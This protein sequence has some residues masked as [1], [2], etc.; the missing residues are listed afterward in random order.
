MRHT[1]RQLVRACRTQREVRKTD[2]VCEGL[3]ERR[4]LSGTWSKVSTPLPTAGAQ[5]MLLLTDGSIMVHGGAHGVSPIWEKLTPVNG[6]YI[7][8]TW[9]SL[10]SMN[11]GRLYFASNVLTSGNVFLVGGEYATDASFS[12]SGEVYDPVADSWTM[13]PNFPDSRFGDDPSELLPDGTVLTGDLGNS[14]TYI[15]NP[16]TNTWTRTGSKLRGDR[17]DEETWVTLPDHSILSYDVFAS[18]SSGSGSAQR[19]IPSTGQWVD[20]GTLPFLL[21]ESD[22]GDELGPGLVLPDGR[23]WMTGAN[24]S[25]AFY[26]PST[27][28]WS[29]GPSIPGG[30][31]ASDD[32]AAMMPNGHVL[33]A[34]SPEE[35][36][37]DFLGPTTVYEFD[38]VAGTYTNVTPS[39]SGFSTGGNAFIA[40]M[41]VLP[42]GQIAFSNE[43]TTI[44]I[45]T[46]FGSPAASQKPTITSIA[47]IS[48]NTFLLGGL[49][50]NGTSEGANYG[51]D[52]GMAENYPIIKLVDT[53]N[54]T[55]FARSTNWSLTGVPIATPE[56]VQFTLPT[57]S[58][59]SV[60]LVTSIANG[61]PSPTVLDVMMGAITT[62]NVTIQMSGSSVQVLAD[63]TSIGTFSTSTFSAVMVSGDSLADTIT[64]N[65]TLGSSIPMYVDG[66]GGDDLIRI[67]GDTSPTTVNGGDGDDEIDFSPVNHNLANIT[68]VV[69]VQGG[70][71][72]DIVMPFD[73]SF[74]TTTA[75]TATSTTL[76]RPGF[77]GLMYASDLESVAIL[78]GSTLDTLSI[79]DSAD[80]TAHSATIA[81]AGGVASVAGLVRGTITWNP[82][83]LGAVSIKS[84]TAADTLAITG[85]GSPTTIDSA[86]G[87]DIIKV[88]STTA[89][90]LQNILNTLTITNTPAL[91]TVTVDDSGDATAQTANVDVAGT[92]ELISTV[93]PSLIRLTSAR[94]SSATLRTG[95]GDDVVNVLRNNISLSVTNN[96]GTDT[97]N[98]GAVAASGLQGITTKVTITDPPSFTNVNFND[99]GDTT[100][101][102]IAITSSGGVTSIA[103]LAPVTLSFN[104][105]DTN[106]TS[107]TTG[108]ASD[109]VNV[110]QSQNVLTFNSAGGA[111]FINVGTATAGVQGIIAPLTITDTAGLSQLTIDDTGDSTAQT[112]TLDA[113]SVTGLAPAAISWTAGQVNFITFVGGAGNDTINVAGTGP[114]AT[115]QVN[116]GK[117]TDTINVNE[118]DPND[119]VIIVPSAG[120]DVINVNADGVGAAG[121]L[122]SNTQQIGALTVGDNGTAALS[123][124]GNVVLTTPSLSLSA[125]S[126]LDV[127]N[128]TLI[129]DYTGVS[130]MDNIRTEIG[131]GFNGGAWTGPQITSS[132]ARGDATSRHALGYAEASSLGV[133]QFKGQ[134]VDATSVIIQYTRYGDNNLDGTID[135]GND[136][137]LLVD[138]LASPGAS[139]WIQGDYTYDGKVDLGNDFNLF[140]V[141]YLNAMTPAAAPAQEG[142]PAAARV[143][144]GGTVAAT[145]YQS[146]MRPNAGP[147]VNDD[148]GAGLFGDSDN[149][150][151]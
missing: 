26:T 120:N 8:G 144:P 42:T 69:S 94:I 19:Y 76:T 4:L 39:V 29:A 48:G 43:S 133:S 57:G 122:F 44:A 107:L 65:T 138:G 85:I 111:D 102:T 143:A 46:P 7:N 70:A 108:S 84:G 130:P 12:R 89:G 23:V 147:S 83:Q 53:S 81:Y 36:S 114:A 146:V 110:K 112:P 129:V 82:A 98:L 33:I 104:T 124:S 55:L 61:I 136:F 75:Y 142:V 27:N 1:I 54:H 77:V 139:T 151:L 88:G 34:V 116:G 119:P 109:T 9:S 49:Q 40:N 150:L 96:A 105:S 134:S 38:P 52:N 45:Y 74:T 30:L 15:Y 62:A 127:A 149:V 31:V 25:T 125:N 14:N 37:D 32:P 10:A 92:L 123:A 2:H 95:G 115:T 56:T 113:S 63:G 22:E 132:T 3:E 13:T 79:D 118:T 121:A 131:A 24:G 17:S 140:L 11:V 64:I 6:S 101:R 51:D 28:K 16:T 135:I 117:G 87:A 137:G 68:G 97:V 35:V 100:A 73:T 72:N 93:A 126:T 47:N 71:G 145:Q 58:S 5:L 41:L 59:P 106:L 60:Y 80:A 86:G 20:A 78:P 91:S 128:D 66:G 67:V 148:S 99:T 50:L 18:L 141:E 90:G 21:N 103:G